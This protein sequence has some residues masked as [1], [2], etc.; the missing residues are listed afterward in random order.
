MSETTQCSD[1]PSWILLFKAVGLADLQLDLWLATRQE[2]IREHVFWTTFPR[3]QRFN[4]EMA[5]ASLNLIQ[6]QKKKDG[7]LEGVGLPLGFQYN[8]LVL[9]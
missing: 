2:N 5:S 3:C 7:H 6:D 9:F 4:A 8:N 1:L